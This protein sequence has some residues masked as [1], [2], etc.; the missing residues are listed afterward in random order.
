MS[1]IVG[2]DKHKTSQDDG[3]GWPRVNLMTSISLLTL[4]MVGFAFVHDT[5]LFLAGKT[6]AVT[7]EDMVGE[8]QEALDRWS[9]SLIK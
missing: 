1:D 3:K 2:P 6:A 4:A 9:L 5:G 8:F 7:G